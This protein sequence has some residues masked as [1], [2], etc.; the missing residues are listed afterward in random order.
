M[1]KLVT[2]I[3]PSYKSGNLVIS[4][5][6]KISNKIKIIVVENS[7]D[8]KL[9]KKI[10]K[11]YSN[12]KVYLQNNIGYG[13][14]IN[15]GA[16]HVKTKYF[17]AMNPDTVIYKNTIQN[18]L[19]AAL[20]IK[21]FGALSPD[22][23]QNKNKNKKYKKKIKEVKM[24]DGG[25]MLFDKNIFKKIKG[26]D[27]KIFL[28]YEEND[29]FHKCNNLNLKLFLIKNSFF[30][31]SQKGDSS[32]AIFNNSREKFYAYLIG[33]WHGQWSKFYY[34]KKYYGFTYSFF[35]CL[36]NL[37]VN[38]IQLFAKGIIFSK[39]TK[40]IYFKIEGLISS[41]IGLPSFKRSKYD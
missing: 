23:I 17:L 14:A 26:F 12:T 16:Y 7:K 1:E 13:R 21:K 36:P 30:Y 20:K 31:H 33:G 15:F 11:N 35:K 38:T 24:L 18:L 9:K 19:V 6:K 37:L 34:L 4:H 32:S 25:A 40:Y 27:N 41:M 5:I 2:V 39:K 28:Y 22:Q 3:L 29:Y 8:K 10:E